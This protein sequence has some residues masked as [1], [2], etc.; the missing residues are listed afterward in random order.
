MYKCVCGKTFSTKRALKIHR[1][2]VHPLGETTFLEL[3]ESGFRPKYT[4]NGKKFRAKN[5]VVIG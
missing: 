1:A 4:K 5:K 2:R 3:L